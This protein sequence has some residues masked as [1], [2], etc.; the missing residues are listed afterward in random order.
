MPKGKC[1]PSESKL[2]ADARTGA[3]IRQVTD[4]PSNH[5]HPFYYLPPC[6]DAMRHLILVSHRTSRPEIFAEFQDTGQL[7]QLTEREDIAEFSLH[8]SHNG[9][10]VYFTTG[11]GAWRVDTETFKEE[12]LVN[13][14]DVA[15]REKEAVGAVGGPTSVSHD[16]RFWAVPVR[17]GEVA[18]LFIIDTA[19][20][21]YEAILECDKTGQPE[22]HPNDASLLRYAGPYW[23]RLWIVNRDGS[24]KRLAY[25]RDVEKKEWIVHET[26]RPGSR[27]IVVANWPHGVIGV[28]VDTGAA[29]TVCTFNAWHPSINRQG[30]LM[31]ADTTFPD[32]G[33]QLFDPRDGAG[34]PFT[35]CHSESSNVGAH[36][37]TDHCPYDDGPVEVY[38][39][40]HTHP[41]PAF[42][43]DGKQVVYTSDRTG[44]AQVYMV[45]IPNR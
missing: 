7:V 45:D 29:R 17:V 20:G 32:I 33:L 43:P 34:E 16:D 13:F 14:A 31:C 38:S 19:S 9:K 3:R 18:P 35:L 24:G 39:P 8:P 27:E 25:K 22:F 44:H 26:W 40:Q 11:T 5:H 12:K 21:N 15:T 1:Y 10:Y 30:T 36:W 23:D 28:D 6:D 42:T 37:D 41:H 4:H 2:F